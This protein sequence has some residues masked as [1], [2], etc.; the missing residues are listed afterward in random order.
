MADQRRSWEETEVN[1][2]K[3]IAE[4]VAT[5]VA[6]RRVEASL[7][8]SEARLSAMLDGSPELIVVVGDDGT[9]QLRQPRRSAGARRDAGGARRS[10][11]AR[12]RPPED[13][14]AGR[15]ATATA[16]RRAP[17]LGPSPC[18]A[19]AAPTARSRLVGDHQRHRRRPDGRRHDPHLPRR[20]VRTSRSSG[21]TAVR[22]D[23]LRYAFDLAQLALDLGPGRVPGAARR[24]VHPDAEMLGVDQVSVDQFDEGR[25]LLTNHRAT[26]TGDGERERPTAR[27]FA[28]R[29]KWMRRLR[30]PSRCAVTQPGDVRRGRWARRA[31]RRLRRRR[32]DV[33]DRDVRRRRAVR[34]ARRVDGRR[35]A[36]LGRRTR[37][38]SCGSSPRRSPTC[39]SGRASTPRCAPAKPGSG[40]SPRPPPTWSS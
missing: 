33:G 40:S 12:P 32:G 38:P 7:R 2:V 24:V 34:R 23:R 28:V 3:R 29:P 36:A 30:Q 27:A 6:K 9:T 8:Q 14:S 22:V 15:A 26:T 25:R 1:L 19:S 11:G 31:P 4:T 16:A 13:R 20:H 39:S 10:A 21:R 18:P 35:R 37:S 5:V 17:T